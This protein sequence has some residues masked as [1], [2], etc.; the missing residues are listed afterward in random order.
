MTDQTKA[1]DELE[2]VIV[3]YASDY[4]RSEYLRDTKWADVE[5]A[6]NVYRDALVHE[7]TELEPS[8]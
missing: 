8:T 4:E 1:R 2:S 3:D 6:L 5:R 7:P